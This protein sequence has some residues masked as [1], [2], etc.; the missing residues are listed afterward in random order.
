MYS[1]RDNIVILCWYFQLKYCLSMQSQLSYLI[2]IGSGNGSLA[3]GA[4]PLTHL[5]LVHQWTG[6]AL[7]QVMSCH[8]FGAKPL[9]EPMLTYC[10]LDSWEQISVKFESEFHH[11]HSRKCIWNCRL[12]KWQPFCSRGDELTE[13]MSTYQIFWSWWGN[14]MC[15]QWVVW[16]NFFYWK[17]VILRFTHWNGIFLSERY[18]GDQIFSVWR[19][20]TMPADALAPK[21]TSASAGMV[22]AV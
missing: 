16:N 11:F 10:Q 3:D 22:L 1:W 20:N 5:P 13:Q 8:L 4:K 21:V 17:F 19:V 15:R 7:V 9:P 2:N 6:S 18:A 12:P 14:Q